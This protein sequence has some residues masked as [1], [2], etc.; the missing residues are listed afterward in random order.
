MWLF[1]PYPSG[2]PQVEWSMLRRMPDNFLTRGYLKPIS[3]IIAH[4]HELFMTTRKQLGP[5]ET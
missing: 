3:R 4:E 5:Y 2:L 1:D